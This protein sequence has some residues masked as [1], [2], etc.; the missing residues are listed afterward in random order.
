M[1][2]FGRV[3]AVVLLSAAVC[4][5][6]FF[7][8]PLWVNDQQIRYHLWRSGVRSK[9]IDAGGHRLHYFEASPP[10]GSP[11]TP[12]VL[13]HGLGARAED[14]SAMV[15]GLAAGGFHVYVPDLLGHGR[16]ARPAIEYSVPLEEGVVVDFMH[17]VGLAHADV[18]GWSMGGWVATKLA[19]DHPE[20]VDRLV[21]DD[22]AGT[23]FQP[24][25]DR[26]AFVPTDAASLSRL[27]AL[28]TPNPPTLPGFV[29]NA[30]L[31]RV[32]E[33]GRIVQQLMDS[34]ET[35]SDLLDARLAGIRQPTLIV[36]G[37]EDKVIPIAIG[38]TMHRA[39]P[40]SVFESVP[41]CGHLAPAECSR[42]VLAGT[43]QFLK[44]QPPIVGGE[45]VL[46]GPP[47]DGSTPEANTR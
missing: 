44:A 41:G 20:M 1:K 45:S 26:N 10:D 46:A 38:E 8:Y 7:R 15:P 23:K 13:V 37:T 22:S 2:F 19:L 28:M 11:G 34:M 42:Q 18:D 25:F 39:I 4:A 24:A 35:G 43:I 36:W 29:V 40:G 21:L 27:L 14:W 47:N 32:S 5:A 31:R 6:I 17:A 9:Y 16:S 12:L 3:M 30:T 33:R